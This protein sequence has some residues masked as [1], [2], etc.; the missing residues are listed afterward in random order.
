MST[1]LQDLRLPSASS[2]ARPAS[3][4]PHPYL[5]LG[6][7]ANTA[8]FSLLDQAFYARFPYKPQQLVVLEGTGNAWD[9]SHP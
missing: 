8:V 1:I 9:G 7:G 5:A 2:A 6:V 4:S 3:R